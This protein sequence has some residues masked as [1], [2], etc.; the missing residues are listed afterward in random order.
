MMLL[1]TKHMRPIQKSI[2]PNIV[3]FSNFARNSDTKNGKGKNIDNFLGN[4]DG[5]TV[6]STLPTTVQKKLVTGLDAKKKRPMDAY[7][8]GMLETRSAEI[9]DILTDCLESKLVYGIF[10]DMPD[11]SKVVSINHVKCNRDMTQ[12]T[13][14]W[15]SDLFLDFIHQATLKHGEKDGKAIESKIFK[16]TTALLQAKESKFRTYLM[17]HMAFRRV[18]RITFLPPGNELSREQ[19]YDMQMEQWQKEEALRLKIKHRWERDHGFA[20]GG[21]GEGRG[22]GADTEEEEESSDDDSDDDSD[23]DSDSDSDD[24]DDGCDSDSGDEESD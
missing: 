20:S 16:K 19:K 11:T 18:P 9:L 8:I 7:E 21:V 12:V 1:M 4:L 22:S 24:V 14:V 15:H 10:K 13:A 23:S 5:T 2:L 3:Q 17:R 6:E